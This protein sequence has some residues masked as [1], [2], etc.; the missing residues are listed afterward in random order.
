MM[1]R[2]RCMLLF[3]IMLMASIGCSEDVRLH[4]DLRDAETKQP[5]LA[6]QYEFADRSVFSTSSPD[7]VTQL[8]FGDALTIRVKAP[9]YDLFRWQ[10]RPRE[11][12]ESNW[13]TGGFERTYSIY[14][15]KQLEMKLTI[16]PVNEVGYP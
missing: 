7:A 13:E 11:H 2:P 9:G 12:F 14:P 15:D 1:R 16:R 10:V 3:Y 8:G 4:V 5:V 6:T